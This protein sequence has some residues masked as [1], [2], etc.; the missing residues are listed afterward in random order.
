[1][2]APNDPLFAQQWHLSRI[3]NIQAIWEDYTG[4]GVSVGVFDDGIDYTHPD[5]APNYDSSL[6]FK[7]GNTTYDPYPLSPNDGH[8]TAVA[9]IIGMVGNNG[10][11]GIGVAPGASLTGINFLVDLPKNL[12]YQAIG[13]AANF[14]IMN[15]SWG[16]APVYGSYQSLVSG[17]GALMHAEFGKAAANGRDGLGT[18]VVLAAGNEASNANGSGITGSRF[19]ITV[20]ATNPD[21]F[22]AS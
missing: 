21:G 14:D 18:A 20:G 15:N 22:V 1:M 11:G 9:G 5:L 8:G 16:Y 7:S 3:G 2:A 13:W 10:I 6:H 4:A 17:Q 19:T 12:F